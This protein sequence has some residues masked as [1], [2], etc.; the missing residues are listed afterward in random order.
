MLTAFRQSWVKSFITCRVFNIPTL[1]HRRLIK[2]CRARH[3]LR[4][5][6]TER[7][8][9]CIARKTPLVAFFHNK[10]QWVIAR[11]FSSCAGN[12]FRPRFIARLIN[13]IG[14]ST[15]METN[16][17]EIAV[18]MIFDIIYKLLFLFSLSRSA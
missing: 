3:R 18:I 11:R 10:C 13:R 16:R 15:D 4:C 14:S 8:N 9:P 1:S 12:I 7:I 6:Q 2:L 5:P 17:I